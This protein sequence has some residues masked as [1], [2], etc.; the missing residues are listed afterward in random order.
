MNAQERLAGSDG[1]AELL[2]EEDA[3][4]GVDRRIDTGAAGAQIDT[5]D[6]EKVTR[7]LMEDE[8]TKVAWNLPRVLLAKN[9]VKL[10]L[11]MMLLAAFAGLALLLAAVGIYGVLSY[12]VRRRVREIGIRMALG[13]GPGAI[14]RMVI[15][16]GMLLAGA[17]LVA[18]AI[19]ASALGHLA[20]SALIGVSPLDLSVYAPV[21]AF[22][23]L[24]ALLA[25]WLPAR[26]AMRVDPMVALRDY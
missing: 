22:L 2:V 18:G 6:A 14:R 3:D 5:G 11:N 16:Q 20:A 25:T 17:G 9:R 7:G 12:T 13:A 4:G 26:R 19:G 15:G 21:T 10:L 23:A 1:V 8:K 24:I